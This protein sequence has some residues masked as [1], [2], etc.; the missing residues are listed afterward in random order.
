MLIRLEK[1]IEEIQIINVIKLYYVIWI[2]YNASSV[3][4]YWSLQ[5]Q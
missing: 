1:W 3:E 5:V 2:C 4:Y